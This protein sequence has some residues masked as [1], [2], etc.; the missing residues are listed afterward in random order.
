[1]SEIKGGA[2]SVFRRARKLQREGRLEEA[3]ALFR[4]AI[5]GKF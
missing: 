4:E 3:I 2:N 5:E 1:M